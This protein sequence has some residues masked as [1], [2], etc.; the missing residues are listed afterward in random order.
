MSI[1]YS[2]EPTLSAEEFKAVLVESTLGERRPVGDMNRLFRML[3]KADIIA[4]ARDGQKLVGVARSVTDF[5]YCCYL[6][7]LAV[8]ATYQGQGIGRR[9]IEET[10]AQ[11]G[12]QAALLLVAAAGAASYYPHIGLQ[13]VPSCWAIPRTR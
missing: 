8:S 13:H 5:S 12:E 7:D 10:R 4:T 1:I 6:S 11:A 3:Q 9:L 2:I